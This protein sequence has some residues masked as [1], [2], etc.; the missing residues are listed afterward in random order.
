VPSSTP[1]ITSNFL[2]EDITISL[3]YRR[4]FLKYKR[5][6]PWRWYHAE[7][8]L[9]QPAPVRLPIISLATD[10]PGRSTHRR[11][12]RC[13][14][15]PPHRESCRNHHRFAKTPV[16]NTSPSNLAVRNESDKS[17][18][19]HHYRR[20]SD[21]PIILR[22][23]R[24]WTSFSRGLP[25]TYSCDVSLY[26]ST[27]EHLIDGRIWL[28]GCRRRLAVSRWWLICL[29][30]CPA[31]AFRW[32]PIFQSCHDFQRSTHELHSRT[33]SSPRPA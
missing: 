8:S 13:S 4:N 20:E 3:H 10:A 7:H 19:R 32:F 30:R 1:D 29:L 24:R 5:R 17:L 9:H 26:L 15:H 25:S 2:V 23:T 31:H 14:W 22:W 21:F 28:R 16:S 12:L 33:R 11:I 6:F 27:P 18:T